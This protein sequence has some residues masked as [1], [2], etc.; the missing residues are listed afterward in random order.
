VLGVTKMA[1]R[2]V[3]AVS[4]LER[5]AWK[6]LEDAPAQPGFLLRPEKAAVDAAVDRIEQ[7]QPILQRRVL[8]ALPLVESLFALEEKPLFA[9]VLGVTL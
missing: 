7:G 6:A 3:M 5:R 4:V 8:D 1:G 2:E 9:H